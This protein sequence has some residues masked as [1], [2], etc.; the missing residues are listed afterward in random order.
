VEG[1]L[2]PQMLVAVKSFWP[3]ILVKDCGLR[4]TTLWLEFLRPYLT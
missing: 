2:S 4:Q 1:P 3:E